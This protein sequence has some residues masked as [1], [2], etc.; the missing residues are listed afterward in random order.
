M[1]PE[2]VDSLINSLRS[3]RSNIYVHVNK[4]NEDIFRSLINKYMESKDVFFVK[5]V[6][7]NYGGI[8]MLL[9]ER[10]LL[11][12]SLKNKENERFHLLTGQDILVRPL[13]ELFAF[14]DSIEFQH[15]EFIKYE[16][17]PGKWDKQGKRF[18]IYRFHDIFNCR[19]TNYIHYIDSLFRELQTIVR[20]RRKKLP[21]SK[22]YYGSGWWSLTKK[23]ANTLLEGLLDTKIMSRMRNTFGPDELL[24]H[25]IINNTADLSV[26]NKD[27]RHIIWPK[28]HGSSPTFISMKDIPSINESG[29]FFARKVSPNVNPDVIKYF[30]KKNKI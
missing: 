15:K 10:E 11:K 19:D 12:E 23:G 27:L 22:L 28:V 6:K 3:T 1:N 29:D 13:D 21:F 26:V 2:Y 18:Y 16:D 8:G 4:A 9:A 7:V 25:C 24:P 17:Y 30:H 14:F 20:I 5:S